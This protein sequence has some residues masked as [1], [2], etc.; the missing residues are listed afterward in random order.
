MKSVRWLLAGWAVLLGS[1]ICQSAEPVALLELK[2][3]KDVLRG[4][5]AAHD[6]Q[7]C[8]LLRR[9]GRLA[10][11]RTDDVTDF[12]EIE[13]RFRPYSSLEVRDQLQTEFGRGFEVKTTPHYVVVEI[14]RAHV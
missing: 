8:W 4:R 11:F 13:A 10:S 12:H 3:G 6:D 14:G 5:I 9:D 7:T 2:I 1:T